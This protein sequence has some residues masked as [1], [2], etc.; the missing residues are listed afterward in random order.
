MFIDYSQKFKNGESIKKNFERV[1]TW[2]GFKWKKDVKKECSFRNYFAPL[3][4]L[5][6][7]DLPGRK[8]V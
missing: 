5:S 8:N 6:Q 2:R 4:Q 7:V 1:G 3:S